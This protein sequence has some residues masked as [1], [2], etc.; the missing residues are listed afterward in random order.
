MI[1]QLIAIANAHCKLDAAA[2][3]HV[4]LAGLVAAMS[5]EQN[6]GRNLARNFAATLG[7]WVH[8]RGRVSTYKVA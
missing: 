8:Q 1:A 6:A 2:A 3:A 7:G 4:T 5:G